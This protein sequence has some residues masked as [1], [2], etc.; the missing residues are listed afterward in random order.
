MHYSKLWRGFGNSLL[1]AGPAYG[2]GRRR[3]RPRQAAQVRLL[4]PS[5]ALDGVTT[6]QNRVPI[7][8]LRPARHP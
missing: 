5:L 3:P 6:A 8:F 7:V 1:G 4:P 2:H